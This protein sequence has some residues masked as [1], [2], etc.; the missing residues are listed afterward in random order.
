[1]A[2]LPV[3][4][5]DHVSDIEVGGEVNCKNSLER[6]W[7]S[8]P[9]FRISNMAELYASRN[10]SCRYSASRALRWVLRV[11]ESDSI[12]SDGRIETEALEVTAEVTKL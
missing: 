6:M 10:I 12:D 8:W 1:V 2:N 9:D 11:A 5:N 7:Y 4:V 3:M